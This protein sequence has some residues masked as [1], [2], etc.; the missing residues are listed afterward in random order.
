MFPNSQKY[1]YLLYPK[2]SATSK[3][4]KYVNKYLQTTNRSSYCVMRT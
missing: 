2:A 1:D 3:T 4:Q